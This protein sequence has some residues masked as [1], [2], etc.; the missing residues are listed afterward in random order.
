MAQSD[1]WVFEAS[2]GMKLRE[3]ESSSILLQKERLEGNW[4]NDSGKLI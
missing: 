2:A 3:H 4:G 1:E